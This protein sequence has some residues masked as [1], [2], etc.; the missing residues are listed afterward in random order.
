MCRNIRTLFN[1]EPPATDEE[2]RAAYQGYVAFWS[3]IDLDAEKQEFSYEVEGSLFPNWVGHTNLRHYEFEGDRV[4][5]KTPPF[6]MG[7]QEIT[8]V[9]IWQRVK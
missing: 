9:L 6:K 5:F 4:T 8:G 7:G 1:F 2:I 3:K